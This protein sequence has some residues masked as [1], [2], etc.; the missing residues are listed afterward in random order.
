MRGGELSGRETRIS[1]WALWMKL[2]IVLSQCLGNSLLGA[3]RRQTE[4]EDR[5]KG[6]LEYAEENTA[7]GN[8]T[9]LES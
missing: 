2:P 7:S 6:M 5:E 4:Q 8:I 9:E 1:R 3:K